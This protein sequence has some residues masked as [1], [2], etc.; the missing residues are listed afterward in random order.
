MATYNVK[1][2]PEFAGYDLREASGVSNKIRRFFK[3]LSVSL[4]ERRAY[5]Q[6]VFELSQLSDRDLADIGIARYDIHSVALD[7]AK[8]PFENV[9]G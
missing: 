1:A 5:R 3:N 8:S 6:A 7:A 4:E 2:H 9:S